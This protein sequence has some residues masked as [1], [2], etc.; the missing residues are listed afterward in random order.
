MKEDELLTL[1]ATFQ[2]IQCEDFGLT[3]L[4]TLIEK[5][6]HQQMELL[7]ATPR[8][9]FIADALGFKEPSNPATKQLGLMLSQVF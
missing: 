8:H 2:C 7:G 9:Y 5:R 1:E 6:C 3:S 4:Q